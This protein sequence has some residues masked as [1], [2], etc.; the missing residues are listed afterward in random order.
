[1]KKVI[2]VIMM[3]LFLVNIVY[4]MATPEFLYKTFYDTRE[5]VDWI[6][7]GEVEIFQNGRYQKS[8]SQLRNYGEILIVDSSQ[9][10]KFIDIDHVDG[11]INYYYKIADVNFV[12]NIRL[13]DEKYGRFESECIMEYFHAQYPNA[14]FEQDV[15]EINVSDSEKIRCVEFTNNTFGNKVHKYVAFEKN[16]FE[17]KI[18]SGSEK[19]KVALL[20]DFSFESVLL[21]SP[22]DLGYTD[23]AETDWHCEDV[24]YATINEYIPGT[25]ETT[26]SPNAPAYRVTIV[27]ALYNADG[28]R[29]ST[30]YVSKFV[31]IDENNPHA[32]AIWWAQECGIV[33]GVGDNK[34]N[35]NG[36][37][38]R[39]DFAVMLLRYMKY[40]KF[41]LPENLTPK[42]F[43][44][45]TEISDYAKEAVY[46]LN[47]LGIMNGKGN[48]IIDPR[49]NVTRAEA[50]AMLH[51]MMNCFKK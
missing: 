9:G 29:P 19:F 25:S 47:T 40:R 10:L 30:L 18:S 2:L 7:Y 14:D 50:A 1:M 35:P 36:N 11:C 21:S 39:Q 12:V 44:D 23:V 13:P 27:S 3:T 4:A 5:L 45:D 22:S 20:K 42:A 16:G 15:R 26:F 34:F 46:T 37:V 17:V 8:I 41:N 31:D 43:T 32:T 24:K 48:N 6:R 28:E 51:R 33:N 38:T 49:G